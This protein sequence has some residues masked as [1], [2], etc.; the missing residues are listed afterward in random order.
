MPPPP[1][2]F[3]RGY[4]SGQTKADFPPHYSDAE[5][6][7]MRQD[8][9]QPGALFD[10][11]TETDEEGRSTLSQAIAECGE[12]N[13]A[14]AERVR[15]ARKPYSRKMQKRGQLVTYILQEQLHILAALA[16]LGRSPGEFL[17]IIQA[18]G[19]EDFWSRVPSLDVDG[20]LTLYRD[21]QSRKV[22]SNDFH[23]IRHL[24]TALPYCDVVVVEKFWARA[25]K[26]TGLGT[27]YET[28]VCSDL[29]ELMGILE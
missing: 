23:D 27:K 24:A 10:L 15:A 4:L 16:A 5:F 20:E 11:L 7:S 1:E 28:V 21:R 14:S 19:L 22:K 18:D 29:A 26:E 12:R 13:A 2:V 3:G 8:S 17:S 6:I 9:E 25:I